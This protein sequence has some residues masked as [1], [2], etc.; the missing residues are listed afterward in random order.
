MRRP[1]ASGSRAQKGHSC[2]SRT[3]VLTVAAAR[4]RGLADASVDQLSTRVSYILLDRQLRKQLA[5][6]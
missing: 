2:L 3:V 1:K 5:R 6:D 4:T